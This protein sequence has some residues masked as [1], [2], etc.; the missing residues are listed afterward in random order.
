MVVVWD[1]QEGSYPDYRYRI[2]AKVW[3]GQEWSSVGSGPVNANTAQQI[4]RPSVVM[5][6]GDN[7]VIHWRSGGEASRGYVV[8]WSGA[9]WLALDA[10]SPTGYTNDFPS[11]ATDATG[12][13]F[14]LRDAMFEDSLRNR[15]WGGR[16]VLRFSE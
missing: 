10:G 9:E 3:D 2:Y 15:I 14:M 8:R 16:Q 4:S 5:G 12:N 7:P 1:E 13:L 6:T 11:I